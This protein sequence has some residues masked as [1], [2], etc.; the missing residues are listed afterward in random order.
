V[1]V[2]G[3]QFT[4]SMAALDLAWAELGLG[5]H[6]FPFQVPSVGQTVEERQRI[7]RIVFADLTAR[8]LTEGQR[9]VPLVVDTLT[10]L[11]HSTLA[12]AVVANLDN[13]RHLFAR[14]AS[15]GRSALRAVL[16][17]QVFTFTRISPANL[18]PAALELLPPAPAGVGH[19]VT[20]TE[21]DSTVRS[22]EDTGWAG[23]GGGSGFEA[24]QRQAARAMFERP[25]SRAGYFVAFGRDRDGKPRHATGLGWF[26]NDT[27]RF[28][29]RQQRARDGRQWSSMA[30]ADH[31]RLAQQLAELVGEL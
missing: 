31:T 17:G 9:L 5:P 4:L 25:K 12:V 28:L 10:V 21:R 14:V 29:T 24:A 20:I 3:Q 7:A 16:N 15:D 2:V 11:A 1:N 30:P 23:S 18:L 19:S 8:G 6:V 27:G 26:D 22:D 13:D